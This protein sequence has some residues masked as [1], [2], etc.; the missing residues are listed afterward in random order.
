M[1]NLSRLS[2]S[3]VTVVVTV[4]NKSPYVRCIESVWLDPYET[5]HC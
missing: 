1:N 3:T 2:Q 5:R 4:Y